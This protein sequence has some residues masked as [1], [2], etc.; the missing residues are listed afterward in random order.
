[1]ILVSIVSE[2]TIP[3]VLFILEN[4]VEAKS[5]LFI[6]TQKMEQLGKTDAIVNTCDLPKKSVKRILLEPDNLAD[7]I[8]KLQ[9]YVQRRPKNE[10][11]LVNITGGTKLLSLAVFSSFPKE[12]GKFAYLPLEGKSWLRIE[13]QFRTEYLPLNTKLNLDQYLTACG[14]LYNKNEMTPFFSHDDAI[15]IF[16]KFRKVGFQMNKFPFNQAKLA[17]K[18]TVNEENLPGTWFEDYVYHEIKKGLDLKDDCIGQNIVLYSQLEAETAN[19]ELDFIFVKDNLLHLLEIKVSTGKGNQ[20]ALNDLM[21]MSAI[22]QKFGLAVRTYFIT[23]SLL[24]RDTGHTFHNG[25]R[26]K[27]QFYAVNNL[28]DQVDFKYVNFDWKHFFNSKFEL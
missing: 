15:H 19:Q 8:K 13:Q 6:T 10:T 27:L 20:N 14:L 5:Y 1:M 4:K 17:C 21:K 2:Q 3:N 18:G 28:A 11:Y 24:R 16:N 25:F 22:R 9:E 23:L 26:E 7:G 12:T